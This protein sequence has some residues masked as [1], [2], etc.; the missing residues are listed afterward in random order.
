MSRTDTT[1]IFTLLATVVRVVASVIAALIVAHAV[2]VFFEANPANPL[3]EFTAGI[4]DSFGWFTEDLFQP[5]DPKIG[6][7]INDA[8]AALISVVAGNL[9]SKL[10]VRLAPTSTAK[11]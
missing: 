9:V 10:I 4:R 6:E 1:R 2:F 8:L 7:T 5:S 11:A 3:V